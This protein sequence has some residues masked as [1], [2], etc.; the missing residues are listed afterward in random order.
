MNIRIWNLHDM[1]H[2]GYGTYVIGTYVIWNIQDMHHIW[3][4]TY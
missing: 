1:E 4:G 2:T 3:Y